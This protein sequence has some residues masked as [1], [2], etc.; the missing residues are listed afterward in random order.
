MHTFLVGQILEVRPVTKTNKSTGEVTSTIDVTVQSVLKDKNNYNVYSSQ[1]I[2]YSFELKPKFD[3]LK[4]KFIAI[5]YRYLST[6]KGIY[7]F[8][9]DDMN[10]IVFDENPFADKPKK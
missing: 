3:L 7:F 4:G 2:Q 5:A 10:F 8:A 1:T 6:S 9:D